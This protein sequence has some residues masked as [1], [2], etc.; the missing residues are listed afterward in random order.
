MKPSKVNFFI[1]CAILMLNIIC[2]H[3]MI[4]QYFFENYATSLIFGTLN[5]LLF[6]VAFYVYKRDRRL[7][8]EGK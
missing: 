5:V 2:T 1:L 6:P 8:R 3:F 4:Q 7:E